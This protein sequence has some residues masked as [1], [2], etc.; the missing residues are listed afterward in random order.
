LSFEGKIVEVKCPKCKNILRIK[1]DA[2]MLADA[3]SPPISITHVHAD[4]KYPA[5]STTIWVD[6]NYDIRAVESSDSTILGQGMDAGGARQSGTSEGRQLGS[7]FPDE[8]EIADRAMSELKSFLEGTGRL[9]AEIARG[10]TD[11][12]DQFFRLSEILQRKM[13]TA[14]PVTLKGISSE[15]PQIVGKVPKPAKNKE[16]ERRP[17]Q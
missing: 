4:P 12:Y 10:F 8:V 1:V 7:L 14:K 6:K 16:G 5:H 17:R 11:A 9:S 2:K 13:A 3:V 15:K